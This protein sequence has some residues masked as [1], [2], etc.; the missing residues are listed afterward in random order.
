[1]RETRLI[2]IGESK[3]LAIP[4]AMI[5]KYCLGDEVVMEEREE[6]I[7][8]HAKEDARKLSWEETFQQTAVEN[9]DWSDWHNIHDEYEL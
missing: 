8:I 6:G 2:Q 3:G 1:M 7:L 4:R 5:T 9:E